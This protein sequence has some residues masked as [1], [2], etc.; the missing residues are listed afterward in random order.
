MTLKTL[1]TGCPRGATRWAYEALKSAG[2]SVGLNSVFCEQS[3]NQYT[4]SQVA[5]CEYEFEVSSFSV[6]FLA[7]PALKD[8]RIIQLRR[9]PIYVASSLYW[10][11]IFQPSHNGYAAQLSSFLERHCPNAKIKYR[12]A[13]WQRTISTVVELYDRYLLPL[14]EQ[15]D[16]VQV[17]S[18]VNSF[19]ETCGV[20]CP[21]LVL[22]PTNISGCRVFA[23]SELDK[24]AVGNE[25]LNLNEKLGYVRE[26]LLP[27]E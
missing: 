26:W 1:I 2:C 11:G 20:T 6:P 5:S 22:P 16:C 23:P 12:G 18:G 14:E 8:I 13:P 9:D 7:H 17:E 21:D 24:F 25:L 10:L 19:L 3:N 4:H 15:S 27:Y